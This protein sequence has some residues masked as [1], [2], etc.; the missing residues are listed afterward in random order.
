MFKN[1]ILNRFL[2]GLLIVTVVLSGLLAG[3]RQREH[4]QPQPHWFKHYTHFHEK[5]YIQFI[6]DQIHNEDDSTLYAALTRDFYHDRHYHPFW[7]QKGLQ[8]AFTDSLL[9][10]LSHA[11]PLHGIPAEYFG[12]DSLRQSITQLVE[13]QVPNND[14]LYPYLYR[15]ERQLTDQYLRYACA[16]RYGAV[17]PKAV[18]GSK[19]Y[20]ETLA[21][22][23]A[24]L[25]ATLGN[26]HRFS[27]YILELYPQSADY[28]VLQREWTKLISDTI[29][30]DKADS[31]VLPLQYRRD[32][33]VAN[34]ERLRWQKK[35]QKSDDTIYIAVNIP[36]YTLCVVQN[37][38][39]VMRNRICCGKTQNPEN[40]PARHRDGLIFPYKAE[41]PL[42]YSQIRTLVLNPEW[43]IPYDIIKNEYYHK[44]VKSNTAVVNREHLYIRD[45]R[46]G[47]YVKPDSIDWKRVSQNNIPYRLHQT[48]GR[49]NALGL[50]KFVF[51]NSESVYLH[52]TNNKGAFKRNKRA[53]S[54]GCVRVQYPDSVAE[55]VYTVN[56]FDTNYT[57]QLHIISGA[58]PTTEK[59][60]EFLEKKHEKDSLYYESLSDWDKQFYRE[61]RPTSVA[62]RKP[63]PLFIEYYTCFVGD[64][65]TVQYREDVYYKDGNIL[66]LLQHPKR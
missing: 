59:G 42:M 64:D 1:T 41:T 12:L 46:T 19:W 50:Y 58:E 32:A 23:T 45:S 7:T 63:I 34:L 53:L 60:E 37:D 66:Y 26:I 31:T 55:W 16:L 61:L 33:L 43:N 22:D 28:K 54:H 3:C 21:P 5:E 38:S 9:A 56:R 29:T 8:E 4:A 25:E 52:D 10:T 36:D 18:H 49:Y 2:A 30:E 44:L 40:M 62:L 57:E 65:G 24:F 48:S 17:S 15:L 6:E 27:D 11:Y 51:A 14:S 39:V 35:H 47:R 20:Y 13:H